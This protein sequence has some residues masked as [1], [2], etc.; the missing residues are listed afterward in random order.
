MLYGTTWSDAIRRK[1]FGIIAD[2]FIRYFFSIGLL[3]LIAVGV[4]AGLG[5][6]IS[7]PQAVHVI[8]P[9]AAVGQP[10]STPKKVAANIKTKATGRKTQPTKSAANKPASSPPSAFAMRAQDALPGGPAQGFRVFSL[11]LLLAGACTGVGWLFGL[12]FGV[13][14]SLAQAQ[15]PAPASAAAA[16]S[17]PRPTSRVNTNLEDISD[18]LTKTLVG[19]GLTQLTMLPKFLGDLAHDINR[20]GFAWGDNGQ[21]LALGIIFYF[22]P[23]GFWLGY[24]GTRTFL[25]RLFDYFDSGL[26]RGDIEYVAAPDNLKITNSGI[27]PPSGALQRIDEAL[28]KVPLQSLTS[29]TEVVAW[30]AAQ[31]RAQNYDAARVGMENALRSDPGNPEIKQQLA[32]ISI[33]QGRYLD[34]ADFMKG[35]PDTPAKV[36]AALYEGQPDGFTRAIRIGE[37]LSEDAKYKDEPNLHVWLACAYAQQYG[38]EQRNGAKSE[39]LAEIK[40]KVIAEIKTAIRLQPSVRGQL[41]SFWRPAPDSVDNDL[42]IFPPDDPDIKPLLDPP[43]SSTGSKTATVQGTGENATPPPAD[44]QPNEPVQPKGEENPDGA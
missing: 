14:R 38:Y 29:N 9:P 21:L 34:S 23:G 20:Y 26:S 13:P 43:D 22:M 25:T 15:Q 16:D 41:Y 12:L 30:A 2:W 37:K 5:G 28:L 44:A 3:A 40:Q 8:G 33:A 31:A 11:G 1:D 19:V 4:G 35:T 42:S 6:T 36:L 32:K 7:T 27:V 24:V 18:W 39:R 10:P 17:S